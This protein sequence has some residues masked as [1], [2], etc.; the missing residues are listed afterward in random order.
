MWL[1]QLATVARR[2]GFPV[3]EVSGWKTRG[4]GEQPH[5]EGIVCHHTGGHNALA[6]VRDGRPDLDGPLSHFYLA[7]TADIY[8]VA[9]GRCWHNAPSTD[10]HFANST[11]LGIEAENLGNGEAWPARQLDA[12]ARLC[13]ALAME[14]GLPASRVKGHKEVNTSKDDPRGIDMNK[15]RAAV[16]TIMRGKL[17]NT[18][19]EICEATW[20][21]DGHVDNPNP[22][23]KATNPKVR[24]GW[25]LTDTNERIQAI[26]DEQV[27]QRKTLQRVL[28]ALQVQNEHL[29][30][31]RKAAGDE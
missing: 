17:M 5:V 19:D 3:H 9:A 24:A 12:Y 27:E 4:H 23:D 2:T 20:Q 25:V 28:D 16:A 13:A 31:L 29:V 7:R 18:P 1:T 30:T 15:W 8:V 14:F 11:A 21:Q 6:V 22:R 26:Q 10:P